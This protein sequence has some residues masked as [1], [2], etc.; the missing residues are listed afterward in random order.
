MERKAKSQEAE[1][2]KSVMMNYLSEIVHSVFENRKPQPIPEGVTVEE[3]VDI[4]RRGQIQYIVISALLKLDLPEKVVSELRPYMFRSIMKTLAQVCAIKELHAKLEEA[5]IRHQMLKGAVLKN[6]YPSPEM[7][8][9]GDVDVMIYENSLDKVEVVFGEMGFQ[10]YKLEKHHVIFNKLPY[11]V[12]EA[13]WTLYDQNV[14][15]S[16]FM[17]YKDNFRAGLVEG[18][19]YTY[20]FSKEDFYVYMIAHMAKHF[21][22]TGCGVRNVLD[23][24]VYNKAYR[25]ELKREVIEAELNKLGLTDFERHIEKLSRIWLDGEESTEFYNN[26]FEYMLECGIYGKGENGVWGQLAKTHTDGKESKKEVLKSY[27]FPPLSYMR[28]YYEWIAKMPWLLPVGWIVR[29]IHALTDRTVQERAKNVANV[30]EEQ[31]SRIGSIY[32]EL[33]LNFKG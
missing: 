21:Y 11:L 16:Q 25:T 17:Y 5:G 26:L 15:K 1:V 4:A 18:A 22:E 30:E 28:D 3:L 31:I 29:G 27:I 33:N 9:M 32:K 2:K 20:D 23:V 7:R 10:K 19:K 24:Y 8:E 13:H 12:L 6:I 14:D